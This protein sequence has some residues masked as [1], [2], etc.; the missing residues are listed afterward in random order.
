V[1]PEN[2]H[3]TLKF[4]GGVDEARL[5]TLID[6]LHTAVRRHAQFAIDVAGLGAFPSATRPRVL[7][8]GIGGGASALG[9]LAET[10]DAA[11]ATAG[12]PREPRPFSPH[13]T[14][15]R[16][17][18]FRRVPALGDALGSAAQRFGRVLVAAAALMRSDLSPRGARYT[19]LAVLPL[20]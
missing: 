4:L 8:A 7:W 16:V 2:L 9:A 10:V 13:V 5:H 20:Q 14:I 18:E 6:V 11:L 17:R 3:V 15:G 19:P 12:L 1:A